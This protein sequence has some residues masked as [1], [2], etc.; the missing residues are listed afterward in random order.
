MRMLVLGTLTLCLCTPSGDAQTAW[1]GETLVSP[2]GNNNTFL[3]D[4]NG[5]T[6]K[7]WS[8]SARPGLIAYL[9]DDGSILRPC[10]D[11]G[12][13]FSGGGAGGRLQRY[14]A[15]GKLTWDYYFSTSSHQQ[16]HDVQP[17]PNGNILLIA[18]ERKSN[19]EAV[20]AGRQSITGEMWPTLIAEI[21]P[22]GAT[23][24][25][26]VWE[27]HAWDHLIQD[28]D[29]RKPNY[30]VV[31][32]HPELIDI[33]FGK[34]SRG[35]WIHANAIDYNEKL[36]QIVFSSHFLHEFYVIDHSTTTKEAAGHTGGRSGKGGDILYRWGN[37]QAY[38]RGTSADQ[39]FFVVHGANWI[40]GGLPG[41]GNILAFDNGDRPGRNNDYSTVVEVVPPV[42]TKGHYFIA[43]TKPF[44]PATPVWSYSDRSSFYSNHLS[45]AYRLPNGNTIICEGTSGY[46]FEVTAAG[47]K[48]WD[49]DYQGSI[50]RAERYWTSPL[51]ADTRTVPAS[52]GGSVGFTVKAGSSHAKRG[53]LLVGG[54]TGTSPGLLLPGGKVTLPINPDVFTSL[55]LAALNTPLFANFLGVLDAGGKGAAKA[56]L[57]ALDSAFVGMKMDFAYCLFGPFDYVSN[58]VRV[59]VVR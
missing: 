19:Q 42:D 6:V 1:K 14:D 10:R 12:G 48:V 56:N 25:T 24:G 53:Y 5:K 17:M 22:V 45:G 59:E 30:G 37:P 29:S 18:W 16:H 2:L 33:N 32:D 26:V 54:I 27:W 8:C 57:P 38:G 13:S 52:T 43:P 34:V 39:K 51:A 20:A 50:A 44:G 35:D 15:N 55:V 46:L 36:D 41:E 58:A 4:M 3:V 47:K 7:T 23:G 40:D 11:S 21:K 9:F 49:Y 28:V 31:A